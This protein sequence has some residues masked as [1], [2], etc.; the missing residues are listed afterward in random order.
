MQNLGFET[1]KIYRA[2]KF[3]FGSKKYNFL[4]YRANTVNVVEQWNKLQCT[5]IFNFYSKKLSLIKIKDFFIANFL[6]NPKYFP[7][8]YENELQIY[9]NWLGRVN[10]IKYYFE[11][12]IKKIK[13]FMKINNFSF[14]DLIKFENGKIPVILFLVWKRIIGIESFI[15]LDN[16][17]SITEKSELLLSSDN[18]LL[19]DERILLLKKYKLFFTIKNIREYKIIIK[20][21][22]EEN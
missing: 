14:K 9:L 22:F 20:K 18:R 15:I 7:S 21:I 2:L 6:E 13:K 4:E 11:K 8:N 17:F 3:H 5:E 10:S 19:Y 16:I 1:Y 12:D